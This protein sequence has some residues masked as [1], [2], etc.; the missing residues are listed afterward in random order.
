MFVPMLQ[1]MRC[2]SSSGKR[3]RQR[4]FR[5]GGGFQGLSLFSRSEPMHRFSDAG[6]GLEF[7]NSAPR[8]RQRR[9]SPPHIDFGFDPETF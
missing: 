3:A 7:P 1:K 2:W 6:C 5:A 9:P 8:W 4:G